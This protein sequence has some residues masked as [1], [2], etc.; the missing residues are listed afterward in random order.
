ME[1]HSATVDVHPQAL[2]GTS[3]WYLI[4]VT[5]TLLGSVNTMTPSA[6]D[7]SACIS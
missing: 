1:S 3:R 7:G 2:L 5:G 4:I 6:A